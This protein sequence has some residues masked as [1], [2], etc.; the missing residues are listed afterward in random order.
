MPGC[1]NKGSELILT[2]TLMCSSVIRKM[3]MTEWRKE[4][5]KVMLPWHDFETELLS[6]QVSHRCKPHCDTE[7][8]Q[9]HAHMWCDS[10]GKSVW[11][12]TLHFQFSIRSKCSF[13]EVYF[14][15]NPHLNWTS[16][17]KG[18]SNWK[19][20]KTIDNKRNSFLLLAI[21]HNQCSQLSTDSARWQH[22]WE[23][24]TMC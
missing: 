12:R 1:P 15:E 3:G 4:R 21:S 9:F 2:T 11:N 13:G 8:H 7:S 17:S 18:M 24:I 10:I 5:R 16:G 19:V 23:L 6:K 22:I 14:A 20:L